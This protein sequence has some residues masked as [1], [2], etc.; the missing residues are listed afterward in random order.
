MQLPFDVKQ[1]QLDDGSGL[2]NTLSKHEASWHKSCKDKINST[3]L[4]R[5]EKRKHQ[6]ELPPHSPKKTRR[7]SSFGP[8]ECENKD[9]EL[10]FFCNQVAGTLGLLMASTFEL[11]KKVRESAM[12]LKRNDLLAKLSSGDMIAIE[13]KYPARCLVPLYNDVH[14]LKIKSNSE[15]EKSMSSLH[16]IA[17]VS[18]SIAWYCICVSW[19]CICVSLC[20][21]EDHRESGETAPVFKLADLGSLYSEKF[22]E[23]GIPKSCLNINTT[24]LK[25]RLLAA[26]PDLTA[27][28]QGKHIL[29]VFND[30]IGM[31]FE[32]LASRTMILRH[33]NWHERP[34]SYGGLCL[35]F[36][37]L[38]KENSRLTVRRNR[39]QHQCSPLSVGLSKAPAS[40]KITRK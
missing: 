26:I 12:K 15:E 7:A 40:R 14:K 33:C 9:E 22:Q 2:F 34:K 5:A 1:N 20:L 6:E 35:V 17:F 21:L 36:N 30:T 18:L 38:S 31:P 39:Y 4:K 28:T 3:K 16:G 23:L 19:Y 8:S 13:A 27:H 32:R 25:E 10:C 11:D 37:S 29:L 24:R